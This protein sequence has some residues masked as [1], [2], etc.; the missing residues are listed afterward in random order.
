[1]SLPLSKNGYLSQ[2]TPRVLAS[3]RTP[4]ACY[5]AL[6]CSVWQ[7]R[8]SRDCP[9]EPRKLA[10]NG[11]QHARMWFAFGTQI[12]KAF[13]SPCL[14]FPCNILDFLRQMQ[15]ALERLMLLVGGMAIRPARLHK[16]G[17]REGI[18]RAEPCCRWNARWGQ[19]RA[20]T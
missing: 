1:M 14:C 15:S 13:A 4:P 16:H 11:G 7:L 2:R 20:K 18:A 12:A 6:D 9:Y 17:A 3:L 10:R 8:F 19:G 5:T